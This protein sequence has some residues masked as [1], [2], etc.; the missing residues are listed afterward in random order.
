MNQDRITAG[1]RYYIYNPYKFYSLNQIHELIGKAAAS[2]NYTRY[3][4]RIDSIQYSVW[5]QMFKEDLKK[6][7]D[8]VEEQENLPFEQSQKQILI[9]N[10]EI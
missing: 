5:L 8:F 4:K 9:Q 10:G 7:L 2:K 3:L 1:A 6:T